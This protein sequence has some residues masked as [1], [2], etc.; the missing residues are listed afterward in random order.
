MK[1]VI[2]RH[3]KCQQ[4]DPRHLG[5]ADPYPLPNLIQEGREGTA[6]QFAEKLGNRCR[7]S[8][9]S[10]ILKAEP[11]ILAA[12]ALVRHGIVDLPS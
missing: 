3:A 1:A 5:K 9:R 11:V 4:Y 7:T 10:G 6:E 2:A 12:E 8:P